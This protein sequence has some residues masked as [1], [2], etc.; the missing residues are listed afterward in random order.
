MKEMKMGGKTFWYEKVM[1]EKFEKGA[2]AFRVKDEEG[3]ETWWV[4]VP[5][6]LKAQIE[7][8]AINCPDDGHIAALCTNE[9]DALMMAS[10]VCIAA[11]VASIPSIVKEEVGR[12]TKELADK[13]DF[14]LD[15][16]EADVKRL[17]DEGKSP[18]EVAEILK[19]RMEEFKKKPAADKGGEW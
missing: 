12:K 9:Q 3:D 16:L 18:K 1:P 7:G 13:L 4:V 6:T 17:K 15:A 11:N 2:C 8:M 19:P 14:D 10:S 5:P